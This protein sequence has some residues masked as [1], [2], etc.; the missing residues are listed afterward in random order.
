MYVG[1]AIETCVQF[2][3]Q[4]NLEKVTD[5]LKKEVQQNKESATAADK[6]IGS[7]QVLGECAC[8]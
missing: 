2:V 3:L 8:L 5:K 7:L 6:M 1:I 4:K